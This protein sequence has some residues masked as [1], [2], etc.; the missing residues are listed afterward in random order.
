MSITQDI[1]KSVG[2]IGC[3]DDNNV[4]HPRGTV[5]VLGFPVLDNPK[6]TLLY[7]VTAKHVLVKLKKEFP[8]RQV[9]VRFNTKHPDLHD[10]VFD[11]YTFHHEWIYNPNGED[12]AVRTKG[13]VEYVDFN[14]ISLELFVTPETLVQEN[15]GP[16]DEVYITGLFYMHPGKTRIL[17]IIR[18][19]ILSR[20]SS[21]RIPS[22]EFGSV[23]AHLVEVRSIGG[24]SG[25]PV[26]VIKREYQLVSS[27][28]KISMQ[29]T[30]KTMLLGLIHGHFDSKEMLDSSYSEEDQK[31]N[32]GIA[33][34]I[35]SRHILD[36]LYVPELVKQRKDDFQSEIKE[37]PQKY[38]NI[39]YSTYL[40]TPSDDS[41]S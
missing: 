14:Y 10:G 9:D 21:E 39:T 1:M 18:S 13:P 3:K 4:F 32:V 34:V 37:K 23:E 41:S 40:T 33:M 2:F 19:G 7:L 26:F 35:P 24:L 15:I 5:F 25:S 17:P 20:L 22:R 30:E 8:D 11:I 12:V 31:I 36:T 27:P 28:P 6:L 29:L 16:G 38:S